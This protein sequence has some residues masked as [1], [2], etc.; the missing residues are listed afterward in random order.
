VKLDSFVYDSIKSIKGDV[1]K[2]KTLKEDFLIKNTYVYSGAKPIKASPLS[3][4]Y[5]G[6]GA[7]AGKLA[8][9]EELEPSII[10]RKDLK[11]KILYIK[12]VD[13]HSYLQYLKFVSPKAV[14]LNKNFYRKVYIEEFP[15]LYT[16]SILEDN[17]DINILIDIDNKAVKSRNFFVD[18]GLG[19]RFII[20]LFPFDSRFQSK[21]DL[22][23]WGSL[24]LFLTLLRRFKNF[25]SDILKIRF[26]AVD[27]KY[28]NYIEL[29]KHLEHLDNVLAVYN[30]DNSGIGNEKLIVKT[31]RYI[32]DKY[33]FEK[34]SEI[35]KQRNK[36]FYYDV[37]SDYVEM[38]I[39]KTVIWFNSQPNEYLYIL[40]KEFLNKNL[41]LDMSEI[42]F[43]IITNSYEGVKVDV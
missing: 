29:K 6:K 43:E 19:S 38:G 23:F 12:D 11:G 32:I 35:F 14:L 9:I 41:Y 8:Y 20:I 28:S 36:K 40:K 16:P 33:H 13:K 10:F 42:I 18:V 24:Q 25:Q 7:I 27:F 4:G 15:I 30:L 22:S 1:K 37:S 39:K 2:I 26:L 17:S 5:S 34:I 31:N 3:F 21:D